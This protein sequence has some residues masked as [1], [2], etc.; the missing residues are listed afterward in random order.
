MSREFQENSLLPQEI[1]HA[2]CTLYKISA[3]ETYSGKE[4]SCV[5]DLIAEFRQSTCIEAKDIIEQIYIDLISS[6]SDLDFRNALPNVHG[7]V[8]KIQLQNPGDNYVPQGW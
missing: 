5:V 2:F 8:K 6:S 1:N 7:V 3:S 4:L